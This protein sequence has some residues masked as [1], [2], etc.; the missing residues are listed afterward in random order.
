MCK[1]FNDLTA[2]LVKQDLDKQKQRVRSWIAFDTWSH[3]DCRAALRLLLTFPSS[4]PSTTALQTNRIQPEQ[5]LDYDLGGTSVDGPLFQETSGNPSA[6]KTGLEQ[7]GHRMK[8]E[9]RTIR[10]LLRRDRRNRAE[11]VSQE[12]NSLLQ[13][14]DIRGAFS[15]L[16]AWYRDRSGFS[17]KPTRHDLDCT[18]IEF[19]ALYKAMQSPGEPLPVNVAPAE[20]NDEPPNEAE[21]FRALENMN[22]RKVPGP[23]K[24]RV[25]DLLYWHADLPE[26]WQKVVELVQK[27]LAGIEI[28]TAFA[29]GI[30][31]L[32]PKSEPG[33][34]RGIALLE[35]VYKL[36]ATI[37]HLRLRDGIEFHPGIHGFRS[38][39]GTGTAIL[40]A[41]L[42]MQLT[43]W[44]CKPLFQVF[45]DLRKAYDTLDRVRTMA[46]LVGYGVGPNL[47][48]FIQTIWDGDTLVPKSGGYFGKPL[49]AERGVRQGDIIS[50]IIFNIVVDCVLRE[51]YQ[52]LGDT[53]LTATFY[54]DDGRI[55]GYSAEA[56]QSGLDLFISLF[57]RVGLHMNADKTKAMVVLGQSPNTR[58]SMTGYKH[59]F[60]HSLP[61]FRARKMTKVT[62]DVCGKSMADSHV[63]THKLQ[64]HRIAPE[65]VFPA[66]QFG[67]ECTY[68][69]DVPG[70]YIAVQCPVFN[71]PA[72]VYR[73]NNMRRHFAWRHPNDVIVIRQE[74]SLPRCPNCRKFVRCITNVHLNSIDCRRLTELRH[75]SDYILIQ[76]AAS[77]VVFNVNGQVIENV[78]AFAYLGRILQRNDL[79]DEAILARLKLAGCAWGRMFRV[80]SAN[81]GVCCKTMGRFYLAVIQ[82]ILLYGSESW[83]ISTRSLLRLKTFHHKCARHMAHQYIRPLPNGTWEHPDSAHVL[84]CCGLSPIETYIARRKTS[85]LHTYAK[86]Y[87]ALYCKCL[88][89]RPLVSSATRRKVWWVVADPSSDNLP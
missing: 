88:A 37:I 52:M 30:L 84:E 56:V 18:H 28:P 14:G 75:Q 64:S 65:W 47:C 42:L 46:I 81:G 76:L 5:G 71:C 57:S 41:K 58:I 85:L 74:G 77:K 22:L 29:Y 20:I 55:A 11:S 33:K 61:N 10:R 23:S 70:R 43:L 72:T 79:D 24:I 17:S 31:V 32:I 1:I 9:S 3:I 12:I 82:Q 49:K 48:Q 4:R 89:S 15:I 27:A 62:C 16:R 68:N 66:S 6:L 26:V 63:S 80:L 7:V 69:V 51:W 45:I 34:F 60:D 40:E 36:C 2:F 39:R 21:I 83:V 19:L 86:P 78:P 73:P 25:E 13:S 59:G 38:G 87:S 53:D 54:A 44:D 50:P 8:E 67:P 35:V